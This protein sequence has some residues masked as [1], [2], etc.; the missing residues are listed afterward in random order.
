[1]RRP[2]L[3]LVVGT[4]ALG[5]AALNT[6]NNLLYLLLGALLGIIALSGWLSEQTLRGVS[7]QRSLPRS[8]R[9]GAAARIEYQLHNRRSKFPGY[10]LTVREMRYARDNHDLPG[11][12]T[13]PVCGE[14]YLSVLQP[15][16]PGVARAEVT[17]A[18]RGV[19]PL[20]G[21]VVA[22]AFPFGLFEKERDLELAAPLIVWP[23]ADKVLRVPLR[24]GRRGR[25]P[26]AGA[27]AAAGAERGD[28]RG[29]REYRSGDDPRDVHWRSTARRGEPIVRQYDRDASDEYWIVL[30]TCADDL[31]LG[32]TAVE[33]AASLFAAASS[34]GERV[35]FAAGSVIL[36]P[37]VAGARIDA[38]FDELAAVRLG[39]QHPLPLP[40]VPPV[41][42]VLVTA[43]SVDG[44]EW[45]D[46]YRAEVPVDTA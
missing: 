4:F 6:A 3:F 35:G 43:R 37:G 44:G 19:Y 38:V 2:G 41:Q 23:R 28:Y 15:G 20:Y 42:C 25:R 22:T 31:E 29:L 45:G 13:R 30:D 27:G 40:P 46:V 10:G 32:E 36:P 34:R 14:A 9:A 33:I 18:R 7:V 11:E 12:D 39:P 24:S 5:L 21:V 16:A 8:V 26:R 17:A 1:M